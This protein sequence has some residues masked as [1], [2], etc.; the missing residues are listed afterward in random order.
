MFLIL[1]IIISNNLQYQDN[2]GYVE[3]KHQFSDCNSNWKPMLYRYTI[4]T[5]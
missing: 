4:D 5:M 1:K 3:L 2:R